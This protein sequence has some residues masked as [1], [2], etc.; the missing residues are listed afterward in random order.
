[1]FY[2][3]GGCCEGTQPQCFEKRRFIKDWVMPCIGVIEDT[4][5]WVDKDSNIGKCFTFYF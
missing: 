1:M 2:Q 5:F 3:A 4:E